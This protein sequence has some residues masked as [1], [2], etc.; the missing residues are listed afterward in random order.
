M[1]PPNFLIIGA[2]RSGTTSLYYYLKQHPDIYMAPI[3]EPAFFAFEGM[4][5][6]S[7][8]TGVIDAPRYSKSWDGYRELFEGATEPLR[9]EASPHYL[10][11]PEAPRRIYSYIP[12]VK[13]I[14]I[15]RNPIERAY[16]HYL[17]HR[18]DDSVDC[19]TFSEALELEDASSDEP[20]DAFFIHLKKYGLYA[21]QLSRY[22]D[23]FDKKQVLVLLYD[24]L[25][26][27]PQAVLKKVCDFLDVD[28]SYIPE[29][30]YQYNAG[31]GVM[32]YRYIWDTVNFFAKQ[33]FLKN[34]LPERLWEKAGEKIRDLKKHSIKPIQK[35]EM[36]EAIRT[37]LREYFREDI[38]ELQKLIGRDL[39]H[40]LR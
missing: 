6:I 11:F 22:Y 34:A 19:Q 15:L 2:A 17:L 38:T 10:Y 32:K 1:K 3:K 20:M 16:S 7:M 35:P 13:L 31:A 9:G 14:T 30:T 21:D 36:D 25:K 39:S 24:D 5:K 23:V 29:E 18:R 4:D 40:W 37:E 28:P 26:E 8:A 27:E 12:H 33:D